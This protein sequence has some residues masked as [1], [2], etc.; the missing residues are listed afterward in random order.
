[1]FDTY[2]TLIYIL[3]VHTEWKLLTRLPAVLLSDI[4]MLIVFLLLG[5]VF[6]HLHLQNMYFAFI[7]FCFAPL[8]RCLSVENHI[9]PDDPAWCHE[10]TSESSV[11]CCQED[12]CNTK[13]NY[14]GPFPGENNKKPNC[15][16]LLELV[17]LQLQKF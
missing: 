1:M 15:S 4:E 12:F 9:P 13:D 5:L 10:H 2:I 11:Q 3:R 6:S 14:A 8:I 17:L 16:I 7:D